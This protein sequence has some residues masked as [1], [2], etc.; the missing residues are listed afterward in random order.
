MA[1]DPKSSK[2]V[3]VRDELRVE[4][5]ERGPLNIKKLINDKMLV[6]KGDSE[7]HMMKRFENPQEDKFDN[8]V[9]LTSKPN[10]V[11]I[12]KE[13]QDHECPTVRYIYTGQV[14]DYFGRPEGI[15]RI[16]FNNVIV[17]PNKSRNFFRKNPS[18]KFSRVSFSR[19]AKQGS[20]SGH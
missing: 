17:E 18:R 5:I 6:L 11:V 14:D 13:M 2:N 19:S 1:F 15:G 9:Y 4:Y 10:E 7:I 8:K 3:L 12:E 20:T 16:I